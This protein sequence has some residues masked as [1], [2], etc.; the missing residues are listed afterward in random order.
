MRVSKLTSST[1][2]G[3]PKV[4]A[5]VRD[6]KAALAEVCIR[7]NRVMLQNVA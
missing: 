1:P 6:A 2:G 5:V 3:R 4:V 7:D